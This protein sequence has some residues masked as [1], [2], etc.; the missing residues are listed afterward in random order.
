MNELIVNIIKDLSVGINK[1]I[2][3]LLGDLRGNVMYKN[4]LF[5]SYEIF[6]EKQ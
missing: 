1:Y 4:S 3:L 2:I 6:R 5:T